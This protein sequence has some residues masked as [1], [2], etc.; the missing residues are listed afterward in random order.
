[1]VTKHYISADELYADSFKLGKQIVDSGFRP[2]FTVALWRGG[3]PPGCCVQEFLHYHDIKTDHVSI[4][5]SRYKGIDVV[6][7]KIKIYGLN[8]IINNA[9]VEDSLLFVDDVF[10]SGITLEEVISTLKKKARKNT[11]HDIRLATVFY[12]P[13]RNKTGR[14]PDFYVHESDNWL[15]F[16]H[17]LEGMTREEIIT[18]RGKKIGELF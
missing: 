15:V 9:N 14:V 5:T 10:D 11:P 17:E 12:K 8:Y 16:P 3:T 4:R 18:V 1:M 13:N 6:E 2:T 7:D